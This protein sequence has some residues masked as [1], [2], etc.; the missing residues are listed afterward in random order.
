MAGAM[1]GRRSLYA[2]GITIA[3][4]MDCI[5]F[6]DYFD[7]LNPPFIYAEELHENAHYV[8]QAAIFIPAMFITITALIDFVTSYI[9]KSVQ[10]TTSLNIATKERAEIDAIV[11]SLGNPLVAVDRRARVTLVND[12]F[13]RLT[14]WTKEEVI[15]KKYDRVLPLM[16]ERGKIIELKNR[17]IMK[18]M[19][20]RKYATKPGIINVSR[21]YYAR[22]DGTV[23][24]FV[25]SLAPIRVPGRVVGATTVFDD[26][27]SIKQIDQLK[28]N[29]MA[30]AS[31]QLKT[32]IAEI[33]GYTEIM[34]QGLAGKLSE[35]QSKYLT[36]IQQITQKTNKLITD[37]LDSTVLE[38]GS[39]KLDVEVVNLDS[40]IKK[41]SA[42]YSFR[43]KQKSLKIKYLQTDKN[44]KVMSD[45]SRLGEI[46]GNVMA[47]AVNY[48]RPNTAITIETKKE[49][50]YG[51]ILVT[52]QGPGMDNKVLKK[53]FQKSDVLSSAPEAEG[54]T[55]V[56][57]YL[58]K[59]LVNL[60][61]GDISVLSSTNEGTTICIKVPLAREENARRIKKSVNTT[62]RRRTTLQTNL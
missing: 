9:R 37:L 50:R 43:V 36:S 13:E 7:I 39:V 41:V 28:T 2:T 25:G 27:S 31:H 3:I 6:V 59:Q 24:P 22:R 8:I 49:G 40:V 62:R 48:T 12:A 61:K 53:I 33:Q 35:R 47:N 60:Q 46:V 54:G 15:G 32:P 19:K 38:Q 4:I 1:L 16:N 18:V 21:Y 23:F 58:A 29:F 26:A 10:L 14:G 11:K 51:A 55:G 30:L 34:L 45:K 56:G 44:I 5:I 20:Q 57:L 42:T 17:P 52:D